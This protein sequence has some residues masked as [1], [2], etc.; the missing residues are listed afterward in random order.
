MRLFVLVLG[1]IGIVLILKAQSRTG[2][3]AAACGILVAVA[4]D[5]WRRRSLLT[6]VSI[7]ILVLVGIGIILHSGKMG[8]L[9]SFYD[10]LYYWK[11]CWVLWLKNP[12]FGVGISSFK[13][14]YRQVAASGVVEPVIAPGGQVFRLAQ[15]SHA[16]NLVLQLLTCTGILGLATFAWLFV[17]ACRFVAN[18]HQ[19]LLLGLIPWPVVFLVVGLTGWNIFDPYY[20]SLFVYFLG[21]MGGPNDNANLN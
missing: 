17:N 18:N 20:T 14:A 12:L 19:G 5:A 7:G 4:Y 3:V 16:H 11:V 2:L 10:R 15:V 9:A 6:M 8:S 1:V 21:F 13:E